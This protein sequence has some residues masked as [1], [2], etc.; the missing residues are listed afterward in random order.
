VSLCIQ[1]HIQSLLH[2][3][4]QISAWTCFTSHFFILIAI[5]RVSICF[6]FFWL[7]IKMAA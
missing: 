5:C 3:L 2:E 6:F 1:F 4:S 7:R